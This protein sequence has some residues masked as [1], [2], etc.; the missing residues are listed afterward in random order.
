VLVLVDAMGGDKA[1]DEIVKGCIDAINESE[2]YDVLLIGDVN[3]INRILENEKF[4]ARRIQLHHTDEVIH[5]DDMPTKAIKSKKNSSM[6]VGLNMLKEK[7]GDV[8]LSAGNTGA[9]LAGAM[10]TLGRIKGV[11]RPALAPIIP[12][13]SGGTMLIDAG[14]NTN[15]KPENLLQFGIIGSL[16]MRNVFGIKNPRVGLVN[17]GQ[18]NRKGSEVIKQAY[19]KLTASDINFIG[20]VEGR[21]IPL[22]AVDVAV[23]DGFVGNVLL[24]FLEGVGFYISKGLKDLYY[25][26][27]KSKLSALIIKKDLKKFFHSMDYEEYGGT[28]VLGV[29]G[30]VFKCHGSSSAKSIK[31]T[32]VTACNFARSSVIEQIRREFADSAAEVDDIEI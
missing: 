23:C 13:A 26:N 22:G 4:D 15:C 29:D 16:Y 14:L 3:K 12:S 30:A 2:G 9:L 10:L 17:I 25:K 21:D 1:P 20:N 11:Q 5:N 6:V 7:Y 31:N 8:F 27:L 24:K 32:I 28:P 19:E 18:E